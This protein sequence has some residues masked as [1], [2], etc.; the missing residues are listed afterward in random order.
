MSTQR[1]I[2][3]IA[4]GL[5]AVLW[6]FALWKWALFGMDKNVSVAFIFTGFAL[7]SAG[8]MGMIE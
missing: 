6:L 2:S 1:I 8:G 4:I 5:G 7:V 3:L